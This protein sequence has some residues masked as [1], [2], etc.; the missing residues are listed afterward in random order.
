MLQNLGEFVLLMTV[1]ITALSLLTL[2][3]IGQR[4]EEKGYRTKDDTLLFL[5]VLGVGF[6]GT[7][8][9]IITWGLVT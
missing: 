4:I 1:M 8:I 6:I 5:F 3:I 7:V 9:G 2:A